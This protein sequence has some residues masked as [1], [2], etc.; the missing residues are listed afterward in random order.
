[1]ARYNIGGS[2]YSKLMNEK[3][4]L[5]KSLV[6]RAEV[7]NRDNDGKPSKQE[8]LRYAEASKVCE[9]IMNL[10][11]SER[12]TYEKWRRNQMD[13]VERVQEIKEI[14]NP[15]PPPAPKPVPK[16]EA[17]PAPKVSETNRTVVQQNEGKAGNVK[18]ETASGFHTKNATKE[19]PAENIEKWYK[20]KPNHGLSD[21]V[22]MEKQKKLLEREAANLGW[23]K[24]DDVLSISPTQSYFFYGPPG[25]GKT[26]LIEAF[27]HDVM[28]KGY[29]FIHLEGNEIHQSLVGVGEKIVSTAFQE[30]IDNA[31]AVIFIDE[32]EN[33]C[34]TRGDSNAQGHERRLTVAFLE[35]RNKMINS[36]KRIIFL[37]ATNYPSKVDAAIRDSAHMVPVPLPP[38]EVRAAYFEKQ[39]KVLPLAEDLSYEYMA[40]ATDNFSYRDLNR[41][42]NAIKL[43]AREK[44]I[45]EYAVKDDEG[46]AIAE[47][48]DEIV[49]EVLRQGKIIITREWFDQIRK[50]NPPDNK[51]EIQKELTEFE[52]GIANG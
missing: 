38:E 33:V 22:G 7:I 10:N 48:S 3:I 21:I 43:Q 36:G 34:G 32:V 2:D 11:L 5:Y 9:E 24:T 14:L 41:C 35:A 50:D 29:K 28:E 52:K 20:E 30:A 23:D 45:E 31:P 4:A 39:L 8:A 44:A 42:L 40:D 16:A 12:A 18:E 6:L 13:C 51:E 1:M 15:T 49:S 19:V 37:G 46:K 26:Y 47:K 17:A 27:A 25:C